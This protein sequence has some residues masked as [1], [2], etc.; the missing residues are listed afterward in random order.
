MTDT[1]LVLHKLGILREHLDRVRRRRAVGSPSVLRRG[2]RRAR[3]A[4]RHRGE[5]CRGTGARRWGA[6]PARHGYAGIDADR[7]WSEL[8]AGLAALALLSH[9]S[10]GE[11]QFGPR[12]SRLRRS[13]GHT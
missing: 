2:I 3:T 11:A 6:A 1:G 7:L 13:S 8:P 12:I 5:P 10:E 4:R 9:G